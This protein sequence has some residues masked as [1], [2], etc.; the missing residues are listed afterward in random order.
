M[1]NL[2]NNVSKW[3]LFV[4]G[5]ILGVFLN[6][7]KPLVPLLKNPVTAIA[8]IGIMIGGVAFVGFTLRAMLGLNA[9]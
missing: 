3:P 5:A 7:V 8:L 4:L 6:A 9:V 1:Q 2:W